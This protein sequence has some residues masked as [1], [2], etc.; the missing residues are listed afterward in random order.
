MSALVSNDGTTIAYETVGDG[1][2]V[3]LVDGAMCFRDS[4]PMRPI[5][6]EL[7]AHFTAVLYDRRGRGESGD[8]PPSSVQR[9]VEDLE[10]LIR[11]VG[12]PVSLFGISSG[13]ALSLRTALALGPDRVSHLVMFEP[14][15]LPEGFLGQAAQYTADLTR[16]LAEGRREDALETFMRHVGVPEQGIAGSR[17]SPTWDAT[18]ALAPTLA[19]DDA[20]MGDSRVPADAA[21]VEIPTLT[22]ASAGSPPMLHHGPQVAAAAIPGATFELIPGTFHEPDPAALAARLAEFVQVPER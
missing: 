13:A 8:T 21:L 20:A 7:A 9:E 22:L 1:P 10:A 17:Q 12:A 14:P 2:P 19:H 15:Y 11:T 6:S 5:A 3:I 18:V 16:A 4:G